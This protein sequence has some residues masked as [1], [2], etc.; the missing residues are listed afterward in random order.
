MIEEIARF[1]L[2]DVPF[3]LPRAARDV[4]A[5]SPASSGCAAASRTRSSG[6]ASPRSTRR[7]SRARRR[8]DL[9][10][11]RADLGRADGAPHDAAPEPR[12]GR[13][14]QRRRR[15]AQRSRCSRSRASTSRGGDLPDERLRVAGHR[16]GR[17]PAREGRRRD[18]VRA[19]SRPSREFERGEHPLLHPGKT[20][21]TPAGIVGELHPRE[22]EGEWGAFELDLGELFAASREPV[23]YEDVITYP[24]VRQD[25]AVAVGE[26]VAV[27]DL[28]AAAREAAGDGAARDPRLRR[29]PRRAGRRRAASRSPSRSPTSRPSGR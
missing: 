17:L 23:I 7:A 13:P 12:R 6:S 2:E 1:R 8:H 27:G 4:R 26:D 21:R 28:V 20:A 11:A 22:L 25:I 10:A 24:A 14:A 18:A 19:R 5:R 29:L 3:T 16:R 15:R 9:E